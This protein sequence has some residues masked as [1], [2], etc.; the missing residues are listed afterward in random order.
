[1]LGISY[2]LQLYNTTRIIRQAFN[3]INFMVECCKCRVNKVERTIDRVVKVTLCGCARGHI[4]EKLFVKGIIRIEVTI[5]LCCVPV[6]N[7]FVNILY[8][9][10]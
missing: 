3:Q 5:L 8:Y 9:I 10:Y 4:S 6:M 2:N 7:C 1:M